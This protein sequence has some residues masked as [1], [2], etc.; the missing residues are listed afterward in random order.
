MTAKARFDSDTQP[1][2]DKAVNTGALPE[3]SSSYL[4]TTIWT[5]E[6][7]PLLGSG[8]RTGLVRWALTPNPSYPRIHATAVSPTRT[9]S[10]R[11][12]GRTTTIYT[13]CTV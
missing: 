5:L 7:P 4:I 9:I 11:Q 3:I 8:A 2:S 6:Q 1:I 12:P 13:A 10:A